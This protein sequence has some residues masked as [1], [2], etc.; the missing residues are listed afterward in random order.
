MTRA[1][2]EYFERVPRLLSELVKGAQ[3]LAM[4]VEEISKLR[5][6]IEDL[7]ERINNE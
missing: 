5:L 2:L 1:E 4:I 3:Y 7:K 6:E